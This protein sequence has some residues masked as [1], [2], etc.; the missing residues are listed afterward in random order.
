M[1][2]PQRNESTEHLRSHCA[3]ESHGITGYSGRLCLLLGMVRHAD[4]RAIEMVSPRME[5]LDYL[6]ADMGEVL[7][8]A[9]RLVCSQW[10][11]MQRYW[12]AVRLCP[13]RSEEH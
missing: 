12:P 4:S 5:R 8:R 2:C 11:P 3:V 10:V 6:H 13:N 7:D 9:F 1:P